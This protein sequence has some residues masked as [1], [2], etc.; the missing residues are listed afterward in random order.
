MEAITILFWE[1]SEAQ[2]KLCEWNVLLFHI[3]AS[4]TH[5][6]YCLIHVLEKV[7]K[8]STCT[9]NAVYVWKMKVPHVYQNVFL[10]FLSSGRNYILMSLCIVL[11]LVLHYFDSLFL[12]TFTVNS[13]EG[14]LKLTAITSR[15]SSHPCQIKKVYMYSPF[16]SLLIF[17]L[18]ING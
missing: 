6:C 7:W 18:T 5:S 14:C 17:T 4:G 15:Y 9:F 12:K 16:L 11:E 10:Q 13:I 3:K 1:P 2:N 8:E